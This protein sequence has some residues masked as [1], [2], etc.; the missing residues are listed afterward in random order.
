MDCCLS[1]A[2][3]KVR[4][5]SSCF[6]P[7]FHTLEIDFLAPIT[8]SR[9]S[10]LRDDA[11]VDRAWAALLARHHKAREKACGL[12]PCSEV[13]ASHVRERVLPFYHGFAS[14]HHCLVRQ[15][16]AM[17]LASNSVVAASLEEGKASDANLQVD[18]R[19]SSKP[20]RSLVL[21]PSGA[22]SQSPAISVWWRV[23]PACVRDFEL[24][25]RQ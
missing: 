23:P 24:C 13:P 16:N 19:L 12:D 8:H 17:A 21:F 7:S 14:A 5:T 15:G 4:Q 6:W 1:V 20:A 25:R 3:W 10:S 11:N 22:R 2:R 18:F 9:G